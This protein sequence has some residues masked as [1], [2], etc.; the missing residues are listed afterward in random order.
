MKNLR[1]SAILGVFWL[2]MLASAA[3]GQCAPGSVC[4]DQDT[5][6][7]ASAAVDELKAAR[8]VI[9]KFQIERSATDAERVASQALIKGLND[10]ISTKDKI[11]V[12]YE[13]INALYRQVIE[14]QQKII[15]NLEKQL[16]KPKSGWQKLWAT[17]EKIALVALGIGL[18]SGI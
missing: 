10:L 4:I 13:R 11:I 2:V 7:K 15:A 3:Y 6:N 14:F 17:L 18:R 1:N 5:L 12:E 9:S 16:A 8:E